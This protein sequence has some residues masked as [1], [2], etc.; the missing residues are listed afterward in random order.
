MRRV[1]SAAALVAAIAAFTPASATEVTGKIESLSNAQ[2][3][4]KL[5][6][7]PTFY[8]GGNA[9]LKGLKPGQTVTITQ[10]GIPVAT[11]IAAGK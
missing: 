3:V 1:L 8:L 10:A 7:K 5:E 9:S 6:G 2:D 11:R 4:I